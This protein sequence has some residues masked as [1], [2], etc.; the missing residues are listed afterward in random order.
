MRIATESLDRFFERIAKTYRRERW[1]S[2]LRPLL[3]T[4]YSCAKQ[5]GDVELSIRLLLEMMGHGVC[6]HWFGSIY[7]LNLLY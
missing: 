2:M 6:L 7:D 3:T 4:W 5:L 1:G